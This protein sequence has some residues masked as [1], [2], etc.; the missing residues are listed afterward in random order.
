M[1]RK[2]IQANTTTLVVTLPKKW[3]KINKVEKGDDLFVDEREGNL[4]VQANYKK[5]DSS[6]SM[7]IQNASVLRSAIGS[8]FRAGFSK[9]ELV[10][11]KEV[12]LTAINEALDSFIGLE[13]ASYNTQK[14]VLRVLSSP[15]KDEFDFYVNKIFMGIKIMVENIL[16]YFQEKE[17]SFKDINDLRKGNLKAREWCMRAINTLGVAKRIGEHYT[18]LHIL[19]KNIWSFVAYWAIP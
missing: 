1:I 19:E 10:F 2:A 17:C 6:T 7:H 4:T 16:N 12:D 14:A 13:I 5:V 3:V 9:I 11:D 8:A 18:F 15:E